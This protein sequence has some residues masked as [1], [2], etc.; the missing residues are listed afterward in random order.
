MW[1]ILTLFPFLRKIPSLVCVYILL[2]LFFSSSYHS[3]SAIF[4]WLYLSGI[5]TRGFNSSSSSVIN[6]WYHRNALLF[7]L[8]NLQPTPESELSSLVYSSFCVANSCYRQFQIKC[9]II[10]NES[11]INS[12]QFNPCMSISC[13]RG[14]SSTFHFKK[15]MKIFNASIRMR[16]IVWYHETFKRFIWKTSFNMCVCAFVCMEE[17]KIVVK[18]QYLVN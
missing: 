3:K 14:L 13:T 17:N 12:Q 11:S 9:W 15:T 18:W 4:F 10:S 8:V 7:L 5:R 1:R 6:R 2:L 16:L